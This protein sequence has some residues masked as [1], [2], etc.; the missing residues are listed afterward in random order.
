[1]LTARGHVVRV[2]VEGRDSN[3]ATVDQPLLTAGSWTGPDGIVIERN[4]AN[5]L[6]AHVG[7]TVQLGRRQLTVRGIAVTVAMATSDPLV[8]VDPG[9]LLAL[10]NHS[11]PMW[12]A[13]NLKLSDPADAPAFADTRNTPNAAWFL[14]TWQGIRADDSTA[15][16]NEQQL[17]DMGSALLAMMAIAG[18]A[19]MVGGRMAEQTRRVGLLKA[20]GATPRLVAL[21]LL[22]ENLLLAVL[23][24]IAGLAIGRVVAPTLARPSASL[25]G[26]AGSPALAATTVLLAAALA[27]AVAV[28]ATGLSA[29]HG[30][31]AS[32]I[33]A[34]NDPARPPQRHTRMIELSSRL[35]V[36]LLLAVRLI[37]RRP[38]RAQL[39]IASITIAVATFIATLM[40]RNTT[41]L[42]VKVAGNILAASKQESLDHLG[43]VLSVIVLVIAAI[44]LLFTTWATVLDAQRPTALAR[45]LGATPRQIAAGLASAQLALGLIA[46]I[47]GIPVGLVFYLVAGGNPKQA[48]PPIL[49]M[50]GVIPTTLLIIAG[51]TAI[52]THIGAHR[53]VAEV[54]RTE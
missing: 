17:L 47:L 53:P 11:Q 30:A 29:L 34:L 33:R 31:R 23:G 2:H 19:V 16:S 37:A 1:M 45:A 51:L 15:I 52:P 10:A 38:R 7:D 20:V 21:V 44:N 14:Q 22:A 50:L 32:T 46:V 36:S 40:M 12:Y 5:T 13:L 26:S 42:G 18:I 35:P 6:G 9:T 54:L 24:T 41:V 8:W 39:A 27:V 3:R 4:F 28:A 48:N 49:L 25:L 43:G